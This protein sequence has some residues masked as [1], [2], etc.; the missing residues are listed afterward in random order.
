MVNSLNKLDTRAQ[1][2][3]Y[4]GRID[5]LR[6]ILILLVVYV[7]F[8]L[9]NAPTHGANLTALEPAFVL[10]ETLFRF[11]VIVLTV[12]SGF[13]FFATCADQNLTKTITKKIRTLAI[14]FLF[15]NIPLVIIMWGMQSFGVTSGQRLSLVNADAT[16]WLD[17]LFSYSDRPVNYP[18]Y[19]I[20]DMFVI[21][22]IGLTLSRVIRRHTLPCIIIAMVIAEYNLDGVLILRT[23]MLPA[24]LIGASLS[25]WSAR[26]DI[27]DKN[28]LPLSLLLVFL[29]VAHY[30]IPLSFGMQYISIV[31]GITAW[32]LTAVIEKREIGRFLMPVTNYAFPIYLI[33]GIIIV[34]FLAAG[35]RVEN[36]LAGLLTY[37]IAPAIIVLISISLFYAFRRITPALASF[38]IGG[39]KTEARKE[40]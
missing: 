6:F 22:L 13:I 18:L 16:T 10:S 38:S 11:S 39:R 35:I 33:H 14:P 21:S 8:P 19:F 34:A 28:I 9:P 37:V 32:T 23:Q 25:I 24:F 29:C 26:L 36:N 40:G 3:A 17:A 12:L 7:H 1:L 4:S 2:E 5:L 30:Y 20:R 15:W 31:G 27:F